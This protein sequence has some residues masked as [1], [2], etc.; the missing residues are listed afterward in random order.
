MGSDLDCVIPRCCCRSSKVKFR[1][2]GLTATEPLDV[3]ALFGCN[4]ASLHARDAIE[5]LCCCKSSKVEL[6][7]QARRLLDMVLCACSM[8]SWYARSAE[9]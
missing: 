5:Q 7:Y 9:E 2:D 3:V 6:R 1:S 4:V 8:V